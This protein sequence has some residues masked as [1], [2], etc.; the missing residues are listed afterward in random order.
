MFSCVTIS[1]LSA[2]VAGSTQ[3]TV[4]A[5]VSGAGS[6]RRASYLSA[7]SA[8]PR[9]VIQAAGNGIIPITA[10]VTSLAKRAA[11]AAPRDA[12]RSARCVRVD[13]R[14]LGRELAVARAFQRRGNPS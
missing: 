11:N 3:R 14:R 5:T 12:S 10:D 13:D 2:L 6:G 7:G 1:I 4:H 8:Q 9:G